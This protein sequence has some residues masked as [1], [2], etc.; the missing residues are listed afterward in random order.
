VYRF[1]HLDSAPERIVSA[2][3]LVGLAFGPGGELVVAS[4]D[5]AYRFE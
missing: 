4:N 3:T 1:S 2:A 5:T